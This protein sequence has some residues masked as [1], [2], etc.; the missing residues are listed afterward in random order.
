MTTATHE[1]QAREFTTAL[2]AVAEQLHPSEGFY[3][4]GVVLARTKGGNLRVGFGD[5]IYRWFRGDTATLLREDLAARLDWRQCGHFAS[6][7]RRDLGEFLENPKAY[8]CVNVG[9]S[10]GF[11]FLR[12][13]GRRLVVGREDHAFAGIDG[14]A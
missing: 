2:L 12:E 13:P 6:D 8:R 3:V 7:L 5:C 1:Q 9:R 11:R 14:L 4:G 10:N